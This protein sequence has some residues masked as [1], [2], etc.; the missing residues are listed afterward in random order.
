MLSGITHILHFT[1]FFLG[2]VLLQ[3]DRV[4]KRIAYNHKMKIQ[5]TDDAIQLLASLGYDPKY[6]GR[7]V[8]RVIQQNVENELAL[9]ILKEEFKDEDTI[10]INT[11]LT[12][13]SKKEL[14]FNRLETSFVST[15]E[16][17]SN[18]SP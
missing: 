3:L 1:F 2:G 18:L 14:S 11:K 17:I 4:E 5:V 16:H 9:G 15:S 8:K 10:L 12:A 6:G 7:P 13:S